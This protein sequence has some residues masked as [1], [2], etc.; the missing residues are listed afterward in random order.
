MWTRIES[1]NDNTTK[2]TVKVQTN[3]RGEIKKSAKLN[4]AET[5]RKHLKSRGKEWYRPS[6]FAFMSTNRKQTA[7]HNA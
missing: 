1:Q 5:E 6:R 7:H 3:H 2:E 4:K